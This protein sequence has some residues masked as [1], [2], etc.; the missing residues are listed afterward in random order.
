MGA[1]R[2]EDSYGMFLTGEY[3]RV[4]QAGSAGDAPEFLDTRGLTDEN[5]D[6]WLFTNGYTLNDVTH[7]GDGYYIRSDIESPI[8]KASLVE[9]TNAVNTWA[10]PDLEAD[11]GARV[12]DTV[13]LGIDVEVEDLL[14]GNVT[15]VND[16]G[17]LSWELL[18]YQQEA[19]GEN[20]NLT[21]IVDTVNTNID[22]SS[23]DFTNQY[24][25]KN[26]DTFV[27][28][29]EYMETGEDGV[30][31][32]TSVPPFASSIS[33]DG[34]EAYNA[35]GQLIGVIEPNQLMLNTLTGLSEE[36]GRNF[37]DL[38]GGNWH[39]VIS[40][41]YN[42]IRDDFST[43]ENKETWDNISSVV[44]QMSGEMVDALAGL[45]VLKAD[46]PDAELSRYADFILSSAYDIKSDA[47][48][49]NGPIIEE[50]RK[51]PL[52]A[53][54][55]ANP[56]KEL[57]ATDNMLLQLE[58]VY[59]AYE[60]FPTQVLAE[61]IG[62]EVLQE[63]PLLLTGATVARVGYKSTVAVAGK[64][65]ATK[66]SSKLGLTT[67]GA[68]NVAEAYGATASSTYDTIYATALRKEGV[69]EET[70]TDAQKDA[71]H[72]LAVP[73]AQNAAA[74]AAVV[75][76]TLYVTGAGSSL[77]KTFL[78]TGKS[79]ITTN[80]V[81]QLSDSILNI[82]DIIV[83]EG[84]SESIEEIIPQ[85]LTDT[86]A[87]E[88]DPNAVRGFDNVVDAGIQAFLTGGG[89]SGTLSIPSV[90]IE[91][92]RSILAAGD[93]LGTL[94]G[95]SA[96]STGNVIADLLPKINP[97]IS[98]VFAN[99][100]TAEEA[101]A[102][103]QELGLTDNVI[104]NNVLN[105]TYDTMYVSTNEAN[106]AFSTVN[107]DYNPT[108]ADIDSIVTS[109]PIADLD[110]A[111]AEFINPKFLSA[112]EVKAAALEE[113]ITL[114]D[115]QA[116]AYVGQ[117]DEAAAVA[118]IKAT[119]DL[120]G[121]TREEAVAGF[122]AQNGYTPTEDE[123]AQFTGA[124]RDDELNE[125]LFGY[126]DDRQ[127]TEAEARK[128]YEDQ[129]YTPTD[130]EIANLVGQGKSDFQANTKTNVGDYVDPLVVT[131]DEVRGKFEELGFADPTETDVTRFVGQFD[132]TAKLGEIK[133]YLPTAQYNSI[134]EVL[135][136]PA[137]SVTQEDVDFV[138]NKIALDEVLNERQ[139]LDYDVTGDGVVDQ[140]DNDLLLQRLGGDTDVQLADTAMF[141]PAT[142][143]YA[144][145]DTQNDTQNQLDAVI[146]LNT[147]LNT[148]I[149]TLGKRTNF[150]QFQD[151]LM[152]ANDLSGQQVSV[153]SGDK[154]NLDYLY[155]FESIFANPQQE[156]LF[157]SPYGPAPTANPRGGNFA[158]GGQ[159]EDK[160]DM[161]LR[162]LGEV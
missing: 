114:T 5:I 133:D 148:Q 88:I 10:D 38:T 129:G 120:Q 141:S 156:A 32:F 12:L 122:Q 31:R 27:F 86:Y 79:T 87:L 155:D 62:K 34:T 104:L 101:T 108:Q 146:D 98:N 63:I 72:N 107:P 144:Q 112:D 61:T 159:V 6:Q 142:G 23:S 85:M 37:D 143:I 136:K 151:M 21:N 149:D 51:A 130:E 75:T 135:G 92:A 1:S 119:Y 77:E 65:W 116:G 152:G 161:L 82:A 64:E 123:L 13:E 140:S 83:K 3:I 84:F 69:T 127:V 36:Q 80:A 139:T 162:I 40:S 74:A 42:R 41:F 46:S 19:I 110:T 22:V 54:Y 128:F 121:T 48:K 153:K 71:A 2:F 147:Q 150:N 55:E 76:G 8:E 105:S 26:Y 14:N 154:V 7:V 24:G 57:S 49:E 99:T 93:M 44:L 58:G 11:V 131:G 91:Q 25:A 47:W 96:T 81:K 126:T 43:E 115:E 67:A 18:D 68:L 28:N 124:I 60:R 9:L 59:A 15:L 103:L 52:N 138:A 125:L 160:N 118:E 158:Q 29:S 111:V 50:L 70:A 95:N 100:S 66:F 39:K 134:A 157:G 89:T 33:Q 16:R 35:Q 73:A 45:D 94:A 4:E 97:N 17:V 90:T 102:A 30:R 106:T 145:L 78:G 56:G 132:E 109:N 53:W 113:G 20:T 117:K 137:R